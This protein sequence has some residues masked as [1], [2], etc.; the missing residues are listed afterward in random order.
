MLTKLVA[1]MACE[2]VSFAE[3]AGIIEKDTVVAAHVL[4]VVNSAAYGHRGTIG[5]IR[6][7][8]ALMGLTKLRNTVMGLSVSRMWMNVRTGAGWNANTFNEHSVATA[9]L[10]DQLVTSA[11][12]NYPEGA[13][14]AGLLHDIG[15]LL[16]AVAFPDDF[17]RIDRLCRE[18]GKS[19][20]ENETVVLGF[21]HAELSAAALARWNLPMEVQDAVANHHSPERSVTRRGQIPLSLI[22]CVADA[23]AR[24]LQMEDAAPESAD[25]PPLP[26]EEVA[27]HMK[28]LGI[29]EAAE[30]VLTEFNKEFE[31][32]R[33]AL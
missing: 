31:A 2:D 21:G 12:A 14:V 7:A 3:L 13:F 4:R 32:M 33:S 16:I 5:S 23:I 19:A 10:A 22:V 1:V 28:V 15:K 29:P 11:P 26:V 30:S 25:A 20:E 9:I 24:R 17:P 27:E 6:H 8:I 18:T